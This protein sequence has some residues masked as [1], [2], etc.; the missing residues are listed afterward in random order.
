MSVAV[1]IAVEDLAGLEVAAQA[2]ADR[3]ELCVD[4]ARGGLTPPATLVQECTARAAAL[5]GARD[6]KPHFDVHVL[7]RCRAEHGDF[8]DRP[9][10]FAYSADEI[11]LMARQAE[12]SVAAGAAGVVIGALTEDGELD[13]PAIE[14]IRDGALSAGSSAMRGVTLTVHRAVDALA[15]RSRREDAAR[16]LLGLGIHRMLTSGGASRALDGAEDLGAMV[17]AA[18]GLLDICAGGGVRPADIGDLVRRTGVADVH[19]SARR[20]PGAPVEDG[21]PKTCT[22][23]AI[24]AAAV[25]AAE[26]L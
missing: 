17:D 3:V 21:A 8:L 20:R 12:E 14:A 15:D 19:L 23:P 5:A 1:E 16:T 26:G 10:E 2:G 6:A 22:D 11:S 18:Q 24:V 13:L 25:D 4:L 9:E 7:I